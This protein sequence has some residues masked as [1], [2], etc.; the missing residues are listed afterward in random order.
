[1]GNLNAMG[2]AA[3]RINGEL[4]MIDAFSISI[5]EELEQ[6]NIDGYPIEDCGI[7]Q[8]IDIVNKK[9]TMKL[10]LGTKSID[11]QSV[12]W[13]LFNTRLQEVP[14]IFLPNI[15][16]HT[17]VA[18]AIALP[19]LTLDQTVE[20]TILSDTKP[21]RVP[22]KQQL[23]GSASD[24]TTFSVSAGSITVDTS[25][26]GKRV[27]VYYRQEFTAKDVTGGN[28]D[29]SRY[30]NIEIFCKICGTRMSDRKIWFPRCTANSGINIDANQDEYTREYTALIA[31][32]LGFKSQYVSWTQDNST[33]RVTDNSCLPRNNQKNDNARK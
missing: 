18:G 4:N 20:V 33:Q 6:E 11:D 31:T 23:V 32:E 21:G 13:F 8:D 29:I 9:S 30:D 19:G 25:H 3:Q 1:M 17:V 10:T 14:T 28:S 2:V 26:N 15:T 27:M 24:P 22:L 12:N 7:K 5:T 16:P